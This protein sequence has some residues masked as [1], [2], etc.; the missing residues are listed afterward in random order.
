ML[1]GKA[2][3][4]GITVLLL[5]TVIIITNYDCI[6]IAIVNYNHRT[7]IAQAMGDYFDAIT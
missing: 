7:F 5:A 6:V 1:P 3:L 4:A 2:K